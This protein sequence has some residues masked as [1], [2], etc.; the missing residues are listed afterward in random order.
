M[1]KME[2][3]RGQEMP[4][5]EQLEHWSKYEKEIEQFVS[6]KQMNDEIL[7]QA[8]TSCSE[9]VT[10]YANNV[11]H[12]AREGSLDSIESSLTELRAAMDNLGTMV[13]EAKERA[14]NNEQE[15]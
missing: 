9:L 4:S 13:K 1:A 3:T 12:F 15:E 5:V 8:I 11:K 14:R 6:L 7:F 2:K 10:S